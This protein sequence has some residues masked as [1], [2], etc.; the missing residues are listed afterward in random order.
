MLA[1]LEAGSRPEEIDQARA[2]VAGFE[3]RLAY[4]KSRLARLGRL[5]ERGTSTV[6]ELQD[7]Q[8]ELQAIEAQLAGSK[9]AL[10][11]V[12]AGAHKEQVAQAA[13]AAAT[14]EA[15]QDQRDSP[16]WADSQF[17]GIHSGP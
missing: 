9:A 15:C 14:Q 3:A 4:A 13:A 16:L 7:A 1:E 5:V 6:D 11:L 2:I 12:T 10:A 17:V 8:T